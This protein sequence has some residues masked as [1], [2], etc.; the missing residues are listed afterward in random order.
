MSFRQ[1]VG[2]RGLLSL[3]CKAVARDSLPPR[4]LF[5][6]PDGVGKQLVVSVAQ[7]LTGALALDAISAE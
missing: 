4:P 3:V 7:A 1:V 2:Y 5:S 6:G